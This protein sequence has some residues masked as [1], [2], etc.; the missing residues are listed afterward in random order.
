LSFIIGSPYATGP[1]GLYPDDIVVDPTG[2]FLYTTNLSSNNVTGFQIDAT[3]G[4][5]SAIPGT[6]FS[7][8]LGPLRMAFEQ[9]GKFAYVLDANASTISV[10]AINATTG[11]LTLTGGLPNATGSGPNDIAIR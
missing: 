11:A 6:P 8:G 7:T 10:Y 9:S 1:S 3:T 5:L 4:A 2:R